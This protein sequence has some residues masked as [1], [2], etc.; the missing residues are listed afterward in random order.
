MGS[1][2]LGAPPAT[3]S[4]PSMG[5]VIVLTRSPRAATLQVDG[6]K[7]LDVSARMMSPTTPYR[8][9]EIT[10]APGRRALAWRMI[11]G[12][13]HT[14]TV[15]IHDGARVVL[16]LGDGGLV[17]IGRVGYPIPSPPNLPPTV[18][19]YS[20]TGGARVSVNGAPAAALQAISKADYIEVALQPSTGPTVFEAAFDTGPGAR[21]VFLLEPGQE[22]ALRVEPNHFEVISPRPERISRMVLRAARA[23]RVLLDH[24]VVGDVGAGAELTT[25]VTPGERHLVFLGA[26]REPGEA[27]LQ[28]PGTSDVV[29]AVKADGTIRIES[30]TPRQDFR[31]H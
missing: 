14:C 16:L 3:A 2:A 27:E 28:I 6:R 19:V 21:G 29:I 24:L 23:G 18:R 26:G 10:V 9:V 11:D 7:A 4:R 31:P 8:S 13:E 5:A 25:M 15:A 17:P 12:R 1:L 20:H 30:A 22:V